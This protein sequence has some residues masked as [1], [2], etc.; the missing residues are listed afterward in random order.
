MTD[1][2]ETGAIDWFL[3]EAPDKKINGAMVPPLLD[4]VD[5]VAMETASALSLIGTSG[6]PRPV[7]LTV[8]TGRVTSSA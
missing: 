1:M 8:A 2:Q 3:I 7:F 5:R 6:R 4:L